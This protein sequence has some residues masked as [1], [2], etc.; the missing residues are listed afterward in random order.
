VVQEQRS[1]GAPVRGVE[2][3]A[4]AER[5]FSETW[6]GRFQSKYRLTF[7]IPNRHGIASRKICGESLSADDMSVEPFQEKVRKI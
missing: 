7:Q 3:Q 4:A 2:L 5:F 6:R 1:V